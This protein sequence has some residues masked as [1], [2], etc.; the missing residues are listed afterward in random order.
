MKVCKFYLVRHGE[1]VA[2]RDNIVGGHFD[3]PLT[4]KGE[5]QARQ[6]KKLF[7]NI[8]FDDAYSSDLLRASQT[9]AIIYGKEVPAGHQLFDLRE[10][11]FGRLE[12]KSADEWMQLNRNYENKYSQLP[13]EE[14]TKYNYA[15]FI[16]S[17]KSV[18]DRFVKTLREIA[19]THVNQTVLIATHGGDIRVILMQ[20]GYAQFLTA[21]SFANAGY[22]ELSCDGQNFH[23]QKVIGVDKSKANAE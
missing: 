5:E 23:I 8:H 12:G 19:Q 14:R 3:S 2:N 1:S 17:D 4:E 18:G 7:A 10:R 22:V 21:G 20:L 16:E 9:G 11:N 6:T 15:D 13:F